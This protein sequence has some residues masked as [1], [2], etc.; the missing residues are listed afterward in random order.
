M[1]NLQIFTLKTTDSVIFET[2]D[3]DGNTFK[4]TNLG[5]YF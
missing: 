1:F 3:D 5:M 4:V 2:K